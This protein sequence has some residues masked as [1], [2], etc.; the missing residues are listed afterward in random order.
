[1]YST[2]LIILFSF[3]LPLLVITFYLC[4]TCTQYFLAYFNSLIEKILLSWCNQF[5]G[6][7]L[8]IYK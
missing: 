5:L 3:V 1:M 8:Y 4:T 6:V 2:I 7:F